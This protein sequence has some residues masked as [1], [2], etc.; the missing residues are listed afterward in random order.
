MWKSLELVLAGWAWLTKRDGAW[1]T[2]FFGGLAFRISQ[3]LPAKG[4]KASS[5]R[6]ATVQTASQRLATAETASQRPATLGAN[7]L[8]LAGVVTDHTWGECSLV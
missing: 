5:Q 4:E 8:F 7:K 3:R 1:N 6:P 2:R